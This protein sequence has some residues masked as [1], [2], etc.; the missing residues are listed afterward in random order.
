MA[1]IE[2]TQINKALDKAPW[3]NCGNIDRKSAVVD[4]VRYIHVL[5]MNEVT[6]KQYSRPSSADV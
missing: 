3:I 1:D 6:G 5:E 2:V 4:G